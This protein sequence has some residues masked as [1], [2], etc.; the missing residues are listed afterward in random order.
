MIPREVL[1]SGLTSCNRW[2]MFARRPLAGHGLDQGQE[3]VREANDQ[4]E[5]GQQQDQGVEEPA[6]WSGPLGANLGADDVSEDDGDGHGHYRHAQGGEDTVDN[7]EVVHDCG[8]DDCG[9]HEGSAHHVIRR[10]SWLQRRLCAGEPL[11]R[12]EHRHHVQRVAE[13]EVREH[14]VGQ[15][16]R[17][18]GVLRACPL[19]RRHLEGLRRVRRHD[20]H[21]DDDVALDEV[22][23]G[24]VADDHNA[25][26]AAAHDGEGH[27]QGLGE[28]PRALHLVDDGRDA[29]H[30][31]ECARERGQHG[32]HRHEAVLRPVR[33]QPGV[34]GRDPLCA[35]VRREQGGEGDEEDRAECGQHR[36]RHELR[37]RGDVAQHAEA[38]EHRRD[39]EDP[40]AE[41]PVRAG[42]GHQLIRDQNDVGGVQADY[43]AQHRDADEDSSEAAHRLGSEVLKAHEPLILL[44]LRLVVEHVGLEEG[45]AA[46]LRREGADQAR[47]DADY[48]AGLLRQRRQ[49]HDPSA[50][51][52][53]GQGH[54]RLQ[55]RDAAGLVRDARVPDHGGVLVVVAHGPFGGVRLEGAV[56]VRRVGGIAALGDLRLGEGD[57]HGREALSHVRARRR[58][59]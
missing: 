5:Q 24:P 29:G 59:S 54:G 7:A 50:N 6:H 30:H 38:P 16:L 18:V 28:L 14:R 53:G 56:L 43:P 4:R 2:F 19:G 8:N 44:R 32:A 39:A 1:H 11:D 31:C 42:D 57:R 52:R 22:A 25:H 21:G 37:D 20:R 41:V 46:L 49:G 27:L 36:H 12:R 35:P 47:D 48:K 15:H 45:A 55:R 51:D 34:V 17:E 9:H 33:V 40:V 10:L 26:V 3:G 23:P 13:H 58:A